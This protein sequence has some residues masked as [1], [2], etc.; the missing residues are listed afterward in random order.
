MQIREVSIYRSCH[1][2]RSEIL[3]PT[4]V[5][6]WY[7]GSYNIGDESDISSHRELEATIEGGTHDRLLCRDNL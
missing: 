5:D 1:L 4:T 7:D 2:E 3:T 6:E